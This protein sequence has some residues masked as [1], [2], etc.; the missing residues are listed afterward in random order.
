MIRCRELSTENSLPV[1]WSI[2]GRYS[3]ALA[4]SKNSFLSTWR[5]DATASLDNSSFCTGVE[6]VSRPVKNEALFVRAIDGKAVLRPIAH[7]RNYLN[8]VIEKNRED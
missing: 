2:S 1:Y 6:A 7:G 3:V 4:T 5:R 8:L